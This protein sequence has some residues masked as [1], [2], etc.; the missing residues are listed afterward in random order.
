MGWTSSSAY[1]IALQRVGLVLI[2]LFG[3]DEA[4]AADAA[5]AQCKRLNVVAEIGMRKAAI[6]QIKIHYKQ[7]SIKYFI[8]GIQQCGSKVFVYYQIGHEGDPGENMAIFDETTGKI[9]FE[10]HQ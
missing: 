9:E 1:R 6:E 3:S 5:A 2:C 7:D 4:C 8:H 10:E